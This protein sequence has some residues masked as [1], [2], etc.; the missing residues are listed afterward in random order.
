[1]QTQQLTVTLGLNTELERQ[2]LSTQT[3]MAVW[4]KEESGVREGST[5]GKMDKQA[6]TQCRGSTKI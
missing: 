5:T 2:S 4:E 3:T 1:M 6:G